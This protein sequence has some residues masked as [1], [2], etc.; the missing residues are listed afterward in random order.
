MARVDPPSIGAYPVTGQCGDKLKGAIDLDCFR[1]PEA[2]GQA[3]AT[4]GKDGKLVVAA[5]GVTTGTVSNATLVDGIL[6]AEVSGPLSMD[7]PAYDLAVNNRIARNRLAA[8]LVTRADDICTKDGASFMANEAL[9]NGLL[10]ILVTG[11]SSAGAIVT[12][13]RAKTV[14]AGVASF[15]SG[16][17]DHINSAVYR[18]QVTQAVS[19]AIDSERARL[20]EAIEAKRTAEASE[21]TVDDMVRMVNEYHQACSFYKGLQL[22][23]TSAKEYPKLKEFVTRNTALNALSP[24]EENLLKAQERVKAARTDGSS[25]AMQNAPRGGRACCGRSR[26]TPAPC[27]HA[28][29]R[30]LRPCDSTLNRVAEAVPDAAAIPERSA[31]PNFRPKASR[32]PPDRAAEEYPGSRQAEDE[33]DEAQQR[34][35][36]RRARAQPLS[37]RRLEA[38]ASGADFVIESDRRGGK[39]F[40]LF[41]AFARERTE[42]FAKFARFRDQLATRPCATGRGCAA[43]RRSSRVRLSARRRSCRSRRSPCPHFRRSLHS[44]QACR[45]NAR[46]ARSHPSRTTMRV[47]DRAGRSSP[48]SAPPSRAFS[49]FRPVTRQCAMPRRPHCAA[50]PSCTSA[51]CFSGRLKA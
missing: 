26:R 50:W 42:P 28:R 10:N 13:E 16:S 20:R 5:G 17:R 18:N 22:A 38:E 51:I 35:E 1:F 48:H 41:V 37:Q 31:S 40:D 21:F 23:L 2:N 25:T 27:F 4:V 39:A 44:S 49:N 19:A 15:A 43:A 12:G 30:R 7:T 14:L 6:R 32:H 34:A 9:T 47:P 36:R 33:R 29:R 8:I 11:L 3:I 45:P 24:A 46:P